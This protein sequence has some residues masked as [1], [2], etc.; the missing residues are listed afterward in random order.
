M[1]AL[2]ATQRRILLLGILTIVV[3]GVVPP[4]KRTFHGEHRTTSTSFAGYRL[5]T[6]PPF[7]DGPRGVGIHTEQLLVQW[8]G[9]VLVTVGLMWVF[10]P[11]VRD[12]E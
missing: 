5:I 9:V 3:M 10:K 11:P 2:S 12:G 6:R 8:L 4:W 7:P 1:H